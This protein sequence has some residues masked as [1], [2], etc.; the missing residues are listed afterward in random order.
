[1]FI[2]INELTVK[3][4]VCWIFILAQVRIT[5]DGGTEKWLQW[6]E[7]NESKL[8]DILFP[9]MI[10]G[11]MDSL[12][13]DVLHYFTSK[14]DE[15]KVVVTPNQDETDFFKALT[16]LSSYCLDKSIRVSVYNIYFG[17]FQCANV[18]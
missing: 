2:Y 18:N 9:D 4:I 5:V 6:V 13:K 11:D 7:K 10:T 15:I 16:E 1:M 8:D 3:F 14:D 17:V 12:S